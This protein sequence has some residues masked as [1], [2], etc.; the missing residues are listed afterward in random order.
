MEDGGAQA[1]YKVQVPEPRGG[2]IN[3]GFREHGN[4]MRL[5][6]NVLL[7]LQNASFVPCVDYCI[8]SDALLSFSS[9]FLRRDEPVEVDHD[10]WVW[11][12]FMSRKRLKHR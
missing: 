2:V 5:T 4:V 11:L 10:F 6:N 9:H 7:I 12:M 8:V 3:V 1:V